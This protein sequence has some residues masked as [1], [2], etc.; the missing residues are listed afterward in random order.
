[1]ILLLAHPLPPSPASKLD[2]QEDKEVETICQCLDPDW[3]VGF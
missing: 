3:D 1:M 2:R